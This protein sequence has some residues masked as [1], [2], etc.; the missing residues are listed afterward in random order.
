MA[1]TNV[2]E[3][4]Q[5]E[6]DQPR[7]P[8]NAPVFD[9]KSAV[10]LG[11]WEPFLKG[12]PFSAFADLREHAPVYWHPEEEGLGSGFWALTRYDDIRQVELDTA[13][14]SSQRG[15]ILMNYGM[16]EGRYPLLHRASLDTMI[17][18]DQ[19]Y[20]MPLR[21]EH[22]PFFTPTYISELR[23]RVDEHVSLLLDGMEQ[24][25][26]VVDMVEM[27]SAELPLFTLCEILGVAPA[28][29]P[30]LVKWMHYLEVA[31]HTM[32]QGDD[33][34]PT[35]F[36]DFVQ[37]V[38]EMFE[39]GKREL[40]ARR[41]EPRN[42]LLS[43]I[44]NAKIDG[45]L[46]S[47]EFL[48]GS[49]LLIVFAGNDTTRNSL[50]GTMRLLTEFP[51]QKARLIDSPDLLGNMVHEAIRM[52]SPVMYMRRTATRDT[53]L[54][55]Q[56]I[57]EGEKVVMYYGA[58]NR[59]PSVF[60]NPDQFDV[61]RGNA[62]DHIAFG[63][64]PHVCLGQRVANMQLE[65]AYSQILTRFPNITWTGEQ[66]IAPNNFVHAISKLMVNLGAH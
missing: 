7:G 26:P 4:A 27:F 24:A 36:G 54:R 52:V 5:E 38:L 64:G 8:A 37:N 51:D 56:T 1:F 25:G 61:S 43:S 50:S 16:P 41:A 57:A 28:D 34:D 59:D 40:L 12:Q 31:G 29:R 63:I 17:C 20:H 22:M 15:G 3:T 49:W 58:A 13:T 66:E 62:K 47:D 23:K 11:H 35:F 44:A 42:D 18:L 65:A 10:N 2:S 33:I 6:R 45:E 53:V 46:L 14:F 55:G 32:A 30:K 39:F 60:S 21:R 9:H 19:P 48:D